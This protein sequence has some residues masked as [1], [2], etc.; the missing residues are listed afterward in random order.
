M[1]T[2]SLSSRRITTCVIASLF[3]SRS[4]C[5]HAI[6]AWNPPPPPYRN[7]KLLYPCSPPALGD[8]RRPE[9]KLLSGYGDLSPPFA[10]TLALAASLAICGRAAVY[11]HL[12]IIQSHSIRSSRSRW[13]RV[14]AIAVNLSRST[15]LCVW[16]PPRGFRIG[17][18]NTSLSPGRPVYLSVQGVICPPSFLS[19]DIPSFLRPSYIASIHWR[20]CSPYVPPPLY[21]VVVRRS[22]PLCTQSY[23]IGPVLYIRYRSRSLLNSSVEG[24]FA[25]EF[26]Q[27]QLSRRSGSHNVAHRRGIASIPKRRPKTN[28]VA[29][30]PSTRKVQG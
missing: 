11:W 25:T 24:P 7:G 3:S 9:G 27:L 5:P 18:I 23:S 13:E 30:H 15:K 10:S 21:P 17:N 1:T 16:Q 26:P 19:V 4:A 14:S 8:V 2:R 29:P 6:A 28:A 12:D 20:V 22:R